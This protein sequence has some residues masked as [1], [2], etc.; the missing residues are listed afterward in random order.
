MERVPLLTNFGIDH[1]R[2]LCLL[3]IGQSELRRRMAMAHHEAFAQRIVVRF[4]LAGLQ[5]EELE[6]YLQH[7]LRLAGCEVP[8]FEP[9]ACQ[10]L[11]QASHGLPRQIN[12]L[13]HYA[14][15]A[16]ALAKARTVSPEH[17]RQACR[18]TGP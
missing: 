9:E 18:E 14:L 13:A 7:V 1:Q 5:R 16:A 3:L 12:S 8:L 11:F 17:V 10:A 2:R 15:T 4:H 6:P